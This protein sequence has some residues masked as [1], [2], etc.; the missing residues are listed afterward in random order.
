M[1]FDR[2]EQ[3]VNESLVVERRREVGMEQPL[4]R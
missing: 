1:I 2:P 4:G 3:K